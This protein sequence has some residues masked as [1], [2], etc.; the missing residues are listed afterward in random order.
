MMMARYGGDRFGV[1]N[2]KRECN[3]RTKNDR[4][5]MVAIGVRKSSLIGTVLAAF[6]G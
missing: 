2:I 6:H 4:S 5:S 1:F 3:Q